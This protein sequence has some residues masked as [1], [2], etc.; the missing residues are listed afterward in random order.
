M[1]DEAKYYSPI[2]STFEVL[3]VPHIVGRCH[4]EELG[5][6]C[7]PMLAEGIAWRHAPHQLAEHTSQM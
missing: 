6:F 7:W 1:V 4:G 3:V 5:P 2:H